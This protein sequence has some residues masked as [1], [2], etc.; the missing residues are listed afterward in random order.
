MSYDCSK[1]SITLNGLDVTR[2]TVL[3]FAVE[4]FLGLAFRE[5]RGFASL[6]AS[7]V[8]YVSI[9]KCY[10]AGEYQA[11]PIL[12]KVL[13]PWAQLALSLARQIADHLHSHDVRIFDALRPHYKGTQKL[14]EHDLVG[15]KVAAASEG[16]LSIEIKCMVVLQAR[17]LQQFRLDL[18]KA[19]AEE[20]PM[21]A[22][23]KSLKKPQ[24][25]QRYVVMV[26]FPSVGSQRYRGIHCE[27]LDKAGLWRNIFGWDHDA[28]PVTRRAPIVPPAPVVALVARPVAAPA[29]L[30]KPNGKRIFHSVEVRKVTHRKVEYAS[31]GDFLRE[32]A[33]EMDSDGARKKRRHLEHWMAKWPN[34]FKWKASEWDSFAEFRSSHGG[35]LTGFGASEKA[36]LDIFGKCNEGS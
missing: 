15:E 28:A 25:L 27:A 7:E 20:H 9:R 30:R 22:H 35:G 24:W 14:G 33:R 23:C 32:M 12:V 8:Q 3:G 34:D 10:L 16:L 1:T 2:M 6:E 13:P 36:C 17:N 4:K 21:W 19:A 29:A 26:D 18:R 11:T 5:K 31:V